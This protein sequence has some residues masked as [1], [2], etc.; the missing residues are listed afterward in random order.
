MIK[1]SEESARWFVEKWLSRL[2][3]CVVTR[4]DRWV[5]KEKETKASEQAEG[6]RKEEREKEREND[7]PDGISLIRVS[8]VRNDRNTQ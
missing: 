2:Y 6:E 3:T 7:T 5:N 1:L 8:R 4:H